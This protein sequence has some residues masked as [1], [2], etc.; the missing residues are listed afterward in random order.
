[1][2]DGIYN[3]AHVYHK[4]DS[5]IPPIN[6]ESNQRIFPIVILLSKH[7]K[8]RFG[9]VPNFRDKDVKIDFYIKKLGIIGSL[10]CVLRGPHLSTD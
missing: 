7:V 3:Y 2:N 5:I 4:F 9:N 8:E 6:V 10:D 1:M